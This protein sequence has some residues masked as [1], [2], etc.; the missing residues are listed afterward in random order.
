MTVERRAEAKMEKMKAGLNALIAETQNLK[1][2][3]E[4]KQKLIDEMKIAYSI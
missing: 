2:E 4:K 1:L 3:I